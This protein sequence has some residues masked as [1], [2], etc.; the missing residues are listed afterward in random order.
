M[1]L[2][3]LKVRLMILLHSELTRQ[4]PP[5]ISQSQRIMI[6]GIL[7]MKFQALQRIL[8]LILQVSAK[9]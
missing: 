7:L 4:S 3:M 2:E 6:D 5:H 1:N 9:Q 8:A